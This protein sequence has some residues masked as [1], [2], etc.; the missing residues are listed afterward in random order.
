MAN[1]RFTDASVVPIHTIFCVGRNYA[2]HARELNNPVPAV[3]VIFIKPDTTI[4]HHG[5]DIR[6]PSM[7]HRVQHE[8]ELVVLL[9]GGGKDISA[10]ASLA[11]VLGYAIGIDVTARDLQDDA[12]KSAQPWTVSKGFD[13]F[14][15]VSDFVPARAVRDPRELTFSLEVNA[16]QV[17]QGNTRDM[18]FD[19]P[20][21]IAYLSTIFTL[22]PGD[23]IFTG[24]PSGV[25]PIEPGD[26]LVAR[27]ADRDGSDLV[28][29]EVQARR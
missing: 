19:V 27:L 22:T 10:E 18:L 20:R 14:A 8:V 13:S 24:T 3:P 7:S 29:L 1:A 9:G 2:D 21:L 23:L 11:L 25:G 12:K 15:P 6:L 16:R 4:V 26:H 28:R 17:Q 5:G